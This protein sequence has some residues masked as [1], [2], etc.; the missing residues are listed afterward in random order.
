MPAIQSLLAFSETA[1][2][3]SFA[4][5]SREI[6]SDPSTLAKSVSRLEASLGLRLFHRTTRQV[7]LTPDGE[8]LFERCQRLLA[9]LEALREEAS[10]VH[11]E[12]SGVLRIDMPVV[13]G[14]Q[15]IL[16]VIA[17]LLARHPRLHLDARF[18]DALVDIVRDG[19][20]VAIRVGPL[21]DSTLVARRIASQDMQ[22]C[23]SPD[24]IARRGM[25]RRVGDLADHAPILFRMPSSGRDR[26]W[27][28]QVAGKPVSLQPSARL[29]FSDGEAMVEAA[30]MG[31]GVAQLPSY[32]VSEAIAAGRLVELLPGLRPPTLPIHALMPATRLVPPRVRVLLDALVE[33]RDNSPRDRAATSVRGRSSRNSPARVAVQS[34][35]KRGPRPRN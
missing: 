35:G 17:R 12:P 20:D 25:P 6:G 34:A 19:I 29:R 14:R 8:R 18:S 3:G 24:Y 27:Q 5:A 11:A 31:L 7:R 26:P 10:G 4:A 21:R 28:L 9:E 30:C 16:P 1:K 33:L 32:M 2:R 23:A 13:F 15:V 22:L